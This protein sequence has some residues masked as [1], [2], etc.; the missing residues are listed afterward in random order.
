MAFLT[1]SEIG[2]NYGLTAKIDI[3][4]FLVVAQKVC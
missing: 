1:T 3:V 4:N 2:Q